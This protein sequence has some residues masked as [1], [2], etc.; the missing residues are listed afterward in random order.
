MLHIDSCA[1]LNINETK[2]QF[3]QK[4]GHYHDKELQN[5]HK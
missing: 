5:K 3:T 1:I 4:G 2:K